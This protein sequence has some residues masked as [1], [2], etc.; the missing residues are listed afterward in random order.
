MENT[1]SISINRTG[2]ILDKIED[3]F[4]TVSG[5]V[6]GLSPFIVFV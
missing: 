1:S 5:I 3:V 6:I 4:I 2:T